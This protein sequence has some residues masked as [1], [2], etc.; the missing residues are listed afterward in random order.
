MRVL[1]LFN[2]T[3]AGPGIIGGV[4]QHHGGYPKCLPESQTIVK[5][6][7]WWERH[8]SN[9]TNGYET[10]FTGFVPTENEEQL[11]FSVVSR[12]ET[13]LFFRKIVEKSRLVAASDGTK[14]V[15]FNPRF[16]SRKRRLSSYAD[17]FLCLFLCFL[18]KRKSCWF[19]Q[20]KT[21]WRWSHIWLSRR[22]CCC[23]CRRLALSLVLP[24]YD[25]LSTERRI[26]L[27]A[28]AA[29]LSWKGCRKRERVAALH[30]QLRANLIKQ[31]QW[32]ERVDLLYL[33]LTGLSCL[34]IEPWS[35]VFMPLC[36]LSVSSFYKATF[37]RIKA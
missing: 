14:A 27:A 9:K 5:V 4:G 3:F 34:A 28:S 8:K 36:K 2:L 20:L 33:W 24:P 31:L 32:H 22:C 18:G 12:S 19:I 16:N 15:F 7:W 6:T 10:T 37:A 35:K 26:R 1:V 21:R 30:T 23:R 13:K 17:L 29:G 11:F 25:L